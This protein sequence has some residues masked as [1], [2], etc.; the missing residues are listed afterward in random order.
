MIG[1]NGSEGMV[2]SV[3]HCPL[4]RTEMHGVPLGSSS[5]ERILLLY[6]FNF[7]VPLQT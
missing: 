4:F 6:H 7:I 2:K 1:V 5:T 3:L